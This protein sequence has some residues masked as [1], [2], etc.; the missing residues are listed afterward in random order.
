MMSRVAVLL[1]S[2]AAS[3]QAGLLG[4]GKGEGSCAAAPPSGSTETSE[5]ATARATACR[6]PLIPLQ[7]RPPLLVVDT[8]SPPLLSLLSLL[9][10]PMPLPQL[11]PP[12]LLPMLQPQLLLTPTSRTHQL[13]PS[14]LLPLLTM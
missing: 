7:L 5:T 9:P 12:L 6:F 2:A 10:L 13:L 8:L 14:T 3:C 1:L 4:A 11:L